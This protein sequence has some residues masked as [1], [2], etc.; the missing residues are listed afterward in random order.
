MNAVLIPAGTDL[1]TYVASALDP[2]AGDLSDC[3]VTF[4]GRRPGHFLRKMLAQRRN[5][6]FIPPHIVS[7]DE[8]IDEI[9]AARYPEPRPDI[10]S[11]DAVAILYDIH[12]GLSHP[13]GGAAFLTPD[14]FFPIGTRI[15][16]DLEELRI[17]G[18]EARMVGE[19]QPLIEEKIPPRS[20]DSLQTLQIFYKEFYSGIA[21]MGYST[22]S[23][24]YWEVCTGIRQSEFSRYRQIM[25]AGFF[26]LTRAERKL[27]ASVGSLPSA[28]LVFEDG[29]GMREKLDEMGIRAVD[30]SR[31][32]DGEGGLQRE[33]AT[34]LPQVRLLQSPDGHGQV[35]ALN[36]LLE[37]PDEHTVIVLPSA[38][39][40]F[41]LQRH[42]L[43]R[44]DSKDY[45]ISL[46]YPL[47]RTP[48]YG[49]LNDLMELIS[50]MDG[51]RVYVPQYLTFILHPY[52]KNALFRG[53]ASAT[54][55]L[56]HSI[57]ESLGGSHT[58]LFLT[59]SDIEEDQVV[60]EQAALNVASDG[61]QA[62][63]QELR[64]HL[65]AIH[66]AT[67][68]KLRSFTNVSDFADT[69]IELLSWV[70][71][72]T[73]ARDHPFFSPFAQ[74]FIE[75]LET[76]SRSLMRDTT[77]QDP[78]SYFALFRKYL[79]GRYQRFLGTPL[80]GLQ[81]LG[82]LETR[83]LT[84]ERVF[85]L[86]VV[87]GILPQAGSEDSLL[88]FSVRRA[89]GLSTRK[90]REQ[91]EKYYFSALASGARELTV[92]FTDN[93]EKEKSRFVEQ[94][95][96]ELQ[97]RDRT[98]DARPYI[99]AI[100]YRVNLENRPPAGIEKTEK[101][102]ALL[103]DRSFSASALDTYL[104][105]PLAFYYS[106]VLGLTKREEVT[107]EYQKVDIGLLVHS[108]LAEFFRATLGRQIEHDDLDPRR[109]AS[110]IE[111]RFAEAYGTGDSGAGRLLLGQIQSHLRHFLDDYMAPIVR[112]TPVTMIALEERFIREWHGFR[113]TG[114]LDAVQRRAGDLLVI[115]YKTGHDTKSH[116]IN[117]GK[118]DPERRDT[119]NTAIGSLQLPVYLLLHEGAAY[120]VGT[121]HAMFLLLGRNRLNRGIE[122][123][124]FADLTE[125]D[126]EFPRLQAVILGILREI[127][128]PE[129]P[130]LPAQDMKGTC[131]ACDFNGI[132]GTRWLAR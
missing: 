67:I 60:F 125:A 5:A 96:W 95:L 75:S 114:R 83:N 26:A 105:C 85:V 76:I 127:V 62:T 50:S 130:F 33:E 59:L 17:E 68:E 94:L 122:L 115:D 98:V 113:L 81:V 54:R 13:L 25:F 103:R 91:M 35:F 86:D 8:L 121:P 79:Q 65:R 15:Y 34:W 52:P 74:S 49:F 47:V 32:A 43:S 72:M 124:L 97:V 92:F 30:K 102:V 46:G 82:S 66:E 40:L 57:E 18:V 110:V 55:V 10:E 1:I 128:S 24:R 131:P 36:A 87:E 84:F 21:A 64:N 4:P 23:S 61:M 37:R 126:R 107:G 29:A 63:A 7:I 45:N 108:I 101:L 116:R 9:Y 12:R 120:Q 129:V 51:E 71:D 53:S 39:T 78:L 19:V 16:N 22:R 118:L 44:L 104:R 3:L 31:P 99:K 28:L 73:T 27:F 93:G 41:P 20:R 123:P 100:Q 69:C 117:F 80:Q 70:H 56:M 119:W 132:C 11:I 42:C 58:R 112:N 89:L 14:S 111:E 106:R 109:L 48:V 88:P 6:S 38:D 2:S 90:E 77:F